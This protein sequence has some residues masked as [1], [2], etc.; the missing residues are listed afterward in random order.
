MLRE[1][2][3]FHLTLWD[4][5]KAVVKVVLHRKS[6]EGKSC[7]NLAACCPPSQLPQQK[8]VLPYRW[9][10]GL[11]TEGSK[12]PRKEVFLTVPAEHSCTA[13]G[14]QC[15]PLLLPLHIY[16]RDTVPLWHTS[17]TDFSLP[18]KLTAR[19]TS[20]EKALLMLRWEKKNSILRI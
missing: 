1:D 17:P 10:H 16:N 20:S 7:T 5:N 15:E 6:G 12:S 3:L 9:K 13:K 2:S 4:V 14:E 19:C 11:G 18:C 8:C